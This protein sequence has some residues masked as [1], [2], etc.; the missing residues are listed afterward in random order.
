MPAESS[1][2]DHSVRCH[3]ITDNK[4]TANTSTDGKAN[5]PGNDATPVRQE[6]T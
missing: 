5:A 3:L 2:G 4:N 1:I 6:K